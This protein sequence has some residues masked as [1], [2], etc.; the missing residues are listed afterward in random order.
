MFKKPLAALGLALVLT[1]PAVADEAAIRAAA[2]SYVNS[3]A[4][5][6][7]MDQMLSGDQIL[8]MMRSQVPGATEEQLQ[9]VSKI[10]EEELAAIRQKMEAAMI[11]SAVQ[12]F[13]L[14]EIEALDAFYRS[15]V[16]SSVMQK[17]PQFMQASMG[18]LGPDMMQMQQRIQQ[19]VMEAMS[20]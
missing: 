19:R 18:Q 7:A 12:T 20:K 6:A 1:A 5:Q 3:E 14:E 10:V 16:G 13:T 9:T 8:G 17:M 2:E 4:Q 15:P 11:D